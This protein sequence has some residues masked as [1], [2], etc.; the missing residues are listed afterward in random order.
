MSILMINTIA[1]F[2][3]FSLKVT[4]REFNKQVQI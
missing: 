2:C 1:T 3:M 4:K